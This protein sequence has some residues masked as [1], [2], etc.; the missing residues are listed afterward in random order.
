MKSVPAS[1]PAATLHALLLTLALA[2]CAKGGAGTSAPEEIEL[3]PE[4]RVADTRAE[5]REGNAGEGRAGKTATA[6][7]AETAAKPAIATPQ[8]RDPNQEKAKMARSRQASATAR[9]LLRGGQSDKAIEEAR[10]ALREHEQNVEAMLVIAEAFYKQGKHELVQSVASSILKVDAKVLSPEEKSQA[11]N[12]MAFAYLQAGSRGEAFKAF[13]SA[14]ETDEHNATAWNNLGVQYMWRGDPATAESCFEY[15]IDLDDKFI[16]ARFNYG[17]ALRANGKVSEAV[18]EFEKVAKERPDWAEIHFNLGVLYLD[19]EQVGSLDEIARLEAAIDELERYKTLVGQGKST[20]E[21]SA[22]KRGPTDAMGN[23]LVSGAQADLY[24]KAAN[25]GIESAKRRLEREQRRK[26]RQEEAEA[27]SDDEQSGEG[28]A[29]PDEG[30]DPAPEQPQSPEAEQPAPEQ[31]APDQQPQQP[32][33]PK[34]QQP[35]PQQPQKPKPQKP[36]G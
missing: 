26:Q 14:A 12:L 29:Q 20:V 23:E 21:R 33:Q 7:P 35:K 2:G 3:P 15:A 30:G 6:E 17:T 8:D 11:Y 18:G 36:G 10:K 31:P 25:K 19:A 4:A 13:K 24:I 34:P 28:D 16:E 9:Q 5:E 22:N 32:Q 1:A 27:E